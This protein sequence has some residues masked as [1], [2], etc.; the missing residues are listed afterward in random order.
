LIG[1]CAGGVPGFGRLFLGD[2]YIFINSGNGPLRGSGARSATASLPGFEAAVVDGV[3]GRTRDSSPS[4]YRLFV[5]LE[6]WVDFVELEGPLGFALGCNLVRLTE[7]QFGVGH[8]AS[9]QKF[10]FAFL[11]HGFGQTCKVAFRPGERKLYVT[12]WH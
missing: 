6:S 2:E 8:S 12:R 5:K 1:V 4:R 10:F 7:A 9:L 11:F 3:Q